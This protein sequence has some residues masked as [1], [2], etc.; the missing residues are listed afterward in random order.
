M[1]RWG[2]KN[3]KRG[4]DSGEGRPTLALV[5]YDAASVP[6]DAVLIW[7]ITTLKLRGEFREDPA[8]PMLVCDDVFIKGIRLGID[9]VA[10]LPSD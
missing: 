10:P 7:Q 6:N 5:G 9:H 1:G 2:E 3:G 4:D 8:L